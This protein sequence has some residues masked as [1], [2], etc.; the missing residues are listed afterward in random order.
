[1]RLGNISTCDRV[2]GG[3]APHTSRTSVRPDVSH[4]QPRRVGH[5]AH[6]PRDLTDASLV[7]LCLD[8]HKESYAE[9]VRRYQDS[10]FGLAYRMT[11]NHE[12]AADMAQEAFI[13]A[14]RYLRRYDPQGSFRNWVMAMC[15]NLTKN[16]FRGV[17][18]RRKAEETHVE[19]HSSDP[20]TPDL[21][22][23]ALEE[24][25]GSVSQTLRVP[26]VLKHVEGLPYEEI[27][28]V[29][30]ISVSAAKMRVKRGRDE[31]VRL[32]RA[33]AKGEIG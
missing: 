27:A 26:L 28:Q 30:G 31:L 4:S 10:V 22:R 8:G 5:D 25:L 1:V 24:A 15:A 17:L 6:D 9:L 20:E 23:A 33:E 11:R 32:L 13:R 2:V 19:L 3:N 16:R 29:L 21:Q 12:D 18:R 7:K 14:Y